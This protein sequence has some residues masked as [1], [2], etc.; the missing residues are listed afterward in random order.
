MWTTPG[1]SA[2]TNGRGPRG[3]A[4]KPRH[5]VTER[6][7]PAESVREA[8]TEVSSW[9]RERL[10]EILADKAQADGCSFFA[11]GEV[12]LT[13]EIPA[14]CV[15]EIYGIEESRDAGVADGRDSSSSARVSAV[16]DAPAVEPERPA[17]SFGRK[18]R[19]STR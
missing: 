5:Q 12:V 15:G 11:R 18:P 10:V 19:F 9:R 17:L 7:A 13:E 8:R 14:A 2:R 6:S 1:W 16:E 3:R 4:A